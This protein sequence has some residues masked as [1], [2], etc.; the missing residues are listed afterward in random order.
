MRTLSISVLLTACFSPNAVFVARD[1]PKQRELDYVAALRRWLRESAAEHLVFCENSGADLAALKQVV[2]DYGGSACV[3]LISSQ[4]PN[5]DP[6]LGKGW[7]EIDIIRNAIEQSPRLRSCDF[8]L[9]VTGRLFPAR[10]NYV[11]ETIN[12]STGIDVYCDLSK[13]LTYADS[14]I[15]AASPAFFTGYLIPRQLE[16]NDSKGLYFEHVLAR[17]IH[18]SMS[19]GLIWHL[20]PCEPRLE[21]ISGTFN[22]RL[23]SGPLKSGLRACLREIKKRVLSR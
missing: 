9:K 11:L 22:S 10:A 6:E 5:F 17:A 15:F 4:S 8:I 20:L 7:G 12:G 21:G 19:R 23:D 3:E 1:D 16:I 13:M 2:S 18:H 14:R